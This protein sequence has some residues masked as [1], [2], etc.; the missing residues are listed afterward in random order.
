MRPKRLYPAS[1]YRRLY[2]PSA[3]PLWSMDEGLPP[4]EDGDHYCPERDFFEWWYFDAAFENGYRLVAILHSSLYNAVDHRPTVDLRLTPPGS[5]SVTAIGRYDRADYRAAADHCDVQIAGCRATAEG[6]G[7]YSLRLRQG[8]IAA[9]L[10]YESSLPGWRPGTGYLFADD[11][12]GHFFKWVVPLPRAEVRGTLT[13]AG[14]TMTVRGVGYHDHNWGNLYLPTAFSR[15]LWGR[16]LAGDW[17]LIFGDVVGRG[18]S[19]AHVTPFMLARDDEILLATDRIHI[20]G[21]EPAQEPRTGANYFRRL[22]LTTVEGPAV[23][24]TLTTHRAIEALD[25][26]APHLPLA[27][28]RHLRGAAEI[29]FYLAQGLP[30]AGRL[31]AWLLGKGSY[32]RWEAN[33]RLCLPDHAAIKAGRALYEVMLL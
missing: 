29:V 12:S 3:G 28:Q 19:P 10:V 8:E 13:V 33:Y 17:M 20:R 26:A 9:D 1:S 11:A 4:E 14:Q 21:E 6:E 7:R 24:L 23:D 25:F 15:W 22:H 5:E 32:L 27:R 31:A 18:R 2:D 16:V 30:V